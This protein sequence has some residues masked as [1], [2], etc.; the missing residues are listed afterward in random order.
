MAVPEQTSMT[1]PLLVVAFGTRGDVLPVLSVCAELGRRGAEV[2]VAVPSDF[3]GAVRRA[4]VAPVDLGISS[5]VLMSGE[6]GRRWVAASQRGPRQALAGLRAMYDAV[7]PGVARV[8]EREHRPGE[9]VASTVMTFGVSRALA[10]ARSARHV[11]LLLAP[12]AP[13]RFPESTV[14]PVRARPS[15]LNQLSGQ[16]GLRAMA[17]ASQPVVDELRTRLGLPRWRVRDHVGAWQDTPTIYGVSPLVMPPDPN[18]PPHTRAVGFWYPDAVAAEVPG[19][20]ADFVASATDPVY[21]GFGSMLDGVDRRAVRDL[22]VRAAGLAGVSAVVAMGRPDP[23]ETAPSYV[24]HVAEVDHAWL[25]PRLRAVVHHGGAGTTAQ[26]MRA[27]VPSIVVPML[28]DQAYW[29][30]RVAELGVGGHAISLRDLT[31]AA[32]GDALRG[33]VRDAAMKLRCEGLALALGDEDGVR[34]AGDQ[35]ER[36]LL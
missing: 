8:L 16:L 34:Q 23:D 1:P 11:Q 17:W 13:S 25:F 35:L 7:A 9:A 12:M 21:I 32:L 30:R 15:R 27:G 18:W 14:N 26:A 4:G 20:L 28:G 19:G 2:R 6:A 33:V 5:T 22:A 10:E 24:R 36:V 3:A 29:G 31:A